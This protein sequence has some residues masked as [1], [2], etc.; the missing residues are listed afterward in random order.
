M[1]SRRTFAIAG[2]AAI[3]AGVGDRDAAAEKKARPIAVIVNAKN[4]VAKLSRAELKNLFLKLR[5]SWPDGK[6]VVALN[7]RPKT[8]LRDAFER[9]VL[10][11]SPDEVG[12]YWVKQRVTGRTTPPRQV[13]SS[14]LARQLVKI[15]PGAIAYVELAHVDPTVKVVA[16]DGVL[17]SDAKYGVTF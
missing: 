6:P 4:P 15:L 16:V 1:I 5:Q 9:K 11:M 7:G 2:L 3:V 8:P 10:G 12:A 13:S 14:V 17:P